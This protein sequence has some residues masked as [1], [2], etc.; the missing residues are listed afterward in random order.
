MIAQKKYCEIVL[1]NPNMLGELVKKI[2]KSM[3]LQSIELALKRGN[4][5]IRRSMA[6]IETLKDAGYKK[7]EIFEKETA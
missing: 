5:S 1:N 2:G 6:F 7:D 3:R 4:T